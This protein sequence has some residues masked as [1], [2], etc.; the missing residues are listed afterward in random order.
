MTDAPGPPPPAEALVAFGASASDTI[1]L[2]GGTGRSWLAGDLVLKP[3]EDEAAAAWIAELLAG[4]E[5]DG[6]RVARPVATSDGRWTVSGW[7]ASR[8]VEGVHAPR[9][10]EVIGVGEAFH[11]AVRH[12]PR[13]EFLDGR[14]DAWALGDRVAW[15]ELPIEPFARSV[16]GL[17]RLADARRSIGEV[18][19]QLIHGDLTENVLFAEG[20][21]PA[22]IDLSPYWRPTGFA[23]AIV[24]ADALLWHG[25][26]AELLETTAHVSGQLLIRALI[27]RLVT[28]VEFRPGWPD[29]SDDL[30][31]LSVASVERAVDLVVGAG[32]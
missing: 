24:A 13:P 32:S 21:A 8:R 25:A 4:I 26:G 19:A 27:Y 11:R 7:T 2:A 1:P 17:R 16:E 20:L 23:S 3:V 5:E 22:V 18:D 9:W 28:H 29:A 12:E 15:E 14:D 30:D 10:A 31:A 6:F